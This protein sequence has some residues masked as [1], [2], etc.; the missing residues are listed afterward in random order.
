MKPPQT[1]HVPFRTIKDITKTLQAQ[2]SASKSALALP[3]ESRRLIQSFVDE[4]D[5]GVS[6]EESERANFELRTFWERY[7]GDNQQKLALFVGMLKELRPAIVGEQ[8]TFYWWRLVINRVIG[9]P[10]YKKQAMEDAQDFL[11]GVLLSDQDDENVEE[12]EETAGSLLNDVLSIYLTKTSKLSEDEDDG[13]AAARVQTSQQVEDVILAF[14]RKQPR[15][16]FKSISALSSSAA[17]RLQALTLLCS[18]LRQ[19]TPHLYLVKDTPLVET[20]LKCLM[21][22]T[23][24]TI[25]SVAL[26]SLIMLLPHIPGHLSPHLPRLFLIYSRILCWEKFSPLSS[27]AQR[28]TVMDD[29]VSDDEADDIGTDST[30]EVYRPEE[31][32]IE[33]NTPE[34]LTYFTYLYGMYPL[35]LMS[36]IRKPRRYLKDCSFP[37][38]D[39]FDLDQAVIRSRT[40]Q[41]R[42]MHL[43]HAN[44]YNMTA[45]K[46]LAD[47]KWTKL[48]PADVVGECHGL[49]VASK[50]TLAS[51]GPPPTAKLPDLPPVPPLNMIKGGGQLSP[52]PSTRSFRSGASWRDT[53]STAVSVTNADGDSPV[54][55][56]QSSRT[57]ESGTRGAFVPDDVSLPAP[58][59]A[60]RNSKEKEDAQSQNNLAYLQREITL[61]RNELNFERWHKAQYSQHISQ[62]MRRNVKEATQ[63]AET[64]NLINANRALRK[65]LDQARKAREATIKDSALTRKQANNIESNMTERFNKLKLEQ[66]TWQAEGDELRRL[67]SEIKQYRDLLV[68]TEARELNKSHQLKLAQQDLEQL[69]KL[70]A[71]LKIAQ[72]KVHEY[73][74]REFEYESNK[75]QKEILQRENDDLQGRL[76]Q[77]EG[78]RERL[79]QAYANKVTELEARLD[80]PGS[81]ASRGSENSTASTQVAIQQAIATSNSKLAQLKKAHT[82]LMEKYTDLELDYHAVKNQ[83]EASQG[84][85]YH[86]T[87]TAG[88]AIPFDP[89]PEYDVIGEYESSLYSATSTSEP[90]NRPYRHPIHAFGVLPD[91]SRDT[92]N[93]QAGLTFAGPPMARRK[94]SLASHASQ[95]SRTPTPAGY[96]PPG[97]PSAY[98]QSAPLTREETKSAFSDNSGG[99]GQ[100]KAKIQA[101]SAVRVY[102][103][104]K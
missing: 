73:E 27:E 91:P 39:A 9:E 68:S 45:E 3:P 77:Q 55:R 46:E 29:R 38:A 25:L 26:T 74:Y 23:S 17:T 54:L 18:L 47:Q 59:S 30:W 11:V 72:T 4:H 86:D 64:L 40:E 102:G 50:Q 103:R 75:R 63:E 101:D 44:F 8:N 84:T 80:L 51:P 65:Q 5:G 37:G 95:S 76:Q 88:G 93:A 32:I 58:I 87:D 81:P 70:Q 71:Q 12:Y 97:P 2:F 43:L 66:E 82:R 62:I 61:L 85:F 99:S 28:D 13:A 67:R 41:F 7:V 35:N 79:R 19:Q 15:V 33:A 31:D 90:T 60:V 104:G 96:G 48:E 24:T 36:Y 34:L 94:N 16:L 78:D 69:E 20:L 6:E 10:T 92:I 14:G 22:D 53:Q 42:Q 98:N 100:K 21:N 1:N 56:P 52:S 89:D 83:L 49:S 57:H